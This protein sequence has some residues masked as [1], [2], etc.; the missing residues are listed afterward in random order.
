MQQLPQHH[1]GKLTKSNKVLLQVD[2][3]KY[4]FPGNA[5]PLP[6]LK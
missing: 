4:P 2:S 1:V 5:L 3:L 6:V